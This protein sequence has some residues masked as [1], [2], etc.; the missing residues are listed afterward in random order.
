MANLTLRVRVSGGKSAFGITYELYSGNNLLT[1][2]R[3][4]GSFTKDFKNLNGRYQLYIYGSGPNSE[5]KNVEIEV[6][7]NGV[8]ILPGSSVNPLI[9]K[10]YEVSG[11]Y[12][13][14]TT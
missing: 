6:F 14:E 3:K 8:Y 1:A 11:H 5:H 7:P 4:R 9:I 13:L 2:E 10:D 12:Y